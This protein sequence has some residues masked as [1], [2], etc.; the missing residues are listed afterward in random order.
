VHILT[1]TE[2]VSD[3]SPHYATVRCF[4]DNDFSYGYWVAQNVVEEMVGTSF[5]SGV[6]NKFYIT[7]EQ[8]NQIIEK[9]ATVYKKKFIE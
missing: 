6:T 4:I 2:G 8:A 7:K 3:T 1:V 5:K 9:G